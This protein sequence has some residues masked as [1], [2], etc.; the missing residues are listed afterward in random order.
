M[1]PSLKSQLKG[2]KEMKRILITI[3]MIA[4]TAGVVFGITY[5]AD[6]Y[7][8]RKGWI[9]AQNKLLDPIWRFMNEVGLILHE[10]AG[11]IYY[12]ESWSGDNDNDGLSWDKAFKSVTYALAASHAEIAT[13]PHYQQRNIIYVRGE[14][15]ETLTKFAQKTDVIGVGSCDGF[16]GARIKGNHTLEAVGTACYMG[17]RFISLAFQAVT[18][19]THIMSVSTGQHGIEFHGCH[20]EPLPNST[21]GITALG[22]HDMVIRGCR[23]MRE[24]ANDNG[25]STAAINIGN[26]GIVDLDISDCWIDAEIGIVVYI[27]ITSRSCSIH[28]N[29]IH[30][31]TLTIDENS[32]TMWIYGN[33]LI[34]DAACDG[35][36]ADSAHDFKPAMSVDNMLTGNGICQWLP[37]PNDMDLR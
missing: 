27:G 25:F 33:R 1:R 35:T 30:A 26:A 10:E 14:F 2:E 29:F 3:L 18:D 20:F 4:L 13:D 17:C 37:D 8:T 7:S 36:E 15:T 9:G 5:D 21:Y 31:T 12:V 28:D 11:T 6:Y 23:F 22:T 16:K 19:T 24:G 32:D 34:S